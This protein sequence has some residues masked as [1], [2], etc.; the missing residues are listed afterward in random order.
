MIKKCAAAVLCALTA[1]GMCLFP[2]FAETAQTPTANANVHTIMVKTDAKTPH[3][4]EAVQVFSGT[5]KNGTLADV[6]WGKDVDGDAIAKEAKESK[7]FGTAGSAAQVAAAVKESNTE[8]FAAIAGKHVKSVSAEG[9]TAS[10]SVS[11]KI[12]DGYYLI[13]P[14]EN[15]KAFS[16]FLVMVSGKDVTASAK[17]STPSVTKLVQNDFFKTD[18][19]WTA[20]GTGQNLHF[21]VGFTVPDTTGYTSFTFK[22]HDKMS[23]CLTFDQK[24]LKIK[25]L[26]S[27]YYTVSKDQGDTF[28]V[29]FNVVQAVADHA[30]VNGQKLTMSYDAKVGEMT[31]EKT[32]SVTNKA[33]L[34]YTNGQGSSSVTTEDAVTQ[35]L[36]PS[37]TFHKVDS[38]TNKAL[39]GAVFELKKDGNAVPM[40]KIGDGVYAVS[41]S[42]EGEMKTNDSGNLKIVGFPLAGKDK[43]LSLSEVKAPSGYTAA[44]TPVPLWTSGNGKTASALRLC[45]EKMP[46]DLYTKDWS[47]ASDGTKYMEEKTAVFTVTL[48]NVKSGSSPAGTTSSKTGEG[49][50]GSS[51]STGGGL[52]GL[53]PKT[54]DDMA[55][56]LAMILIF[57]SAA[58][59]LTMAIKRRKATRK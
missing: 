22:L 13:R 4:Y 9:T 48:F 52:G 24:S 50:S 39:A 27:K 32:D 40:K 25:G 11:F 1:F 8:D 53:I 56:L 42:G 46:E 19:T 31:S 17:P 41:E 49:G 20:A 6:H 33:S 3:S 26:D 21:T 5:A 7:K 43:Q 38:K 55:R 29:N 36:V 23:E 34:E 14:K 44:K 51:G 10:G 57:G 35:I 18:G 59:A 2:S 54:G 12:P 30:V 47:S 16:P 37:V 15:T 28:T 58:G 45:T